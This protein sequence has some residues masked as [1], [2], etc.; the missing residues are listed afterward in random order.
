MN[1]ADRILEAVRGARDDITADR[2]I[3]WA[4]PSEP[5]NALAQLRDR[6]R[7]AL[8]AAA[9][10]TGGPSI[11]MVRDAMADAFDPHAMC[12]PGWTPQKAL[13]A[14]LVARMTSPPSQRGGDVGQ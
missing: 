1:D 6:V 4:D 3:L 9:I 14:A 7:A 10:G 8:S 11:E 12:Q 2:V 13:H 5:G